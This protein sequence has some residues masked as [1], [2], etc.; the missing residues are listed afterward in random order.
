MKTTSELCGNLERRVEEAT[1][2]YASWNSD[3]GLRVYRDPRSGEHFCT[4][5]ADR[6]TTMGEAGAL[7]EARAIAAAKALGWVK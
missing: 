3:Y 2:C 4:G 7:L 6:N 1:G 5:F